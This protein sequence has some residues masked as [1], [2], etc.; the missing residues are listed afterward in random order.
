MK[1][2]L[3]WIG[4]IVGVVLLLIIIAS[5]VIMLIVDKEF[6]VTQMESALNRHVTIE[7]IDVG[8]FSVVSG[9]D[10]KDIK[11]SNFKT[12]RQ[13]SALKGKPVKPRDIFV[14]LKAFNF[15]ISF[16][17]FFFKLRYFFL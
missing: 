14:G 8:I 10:V 3:K 16:L 15:K 5:V 4:L 9:I 2:L 11:I 13:L 1:R 7:D 6:I 12:E 17:M